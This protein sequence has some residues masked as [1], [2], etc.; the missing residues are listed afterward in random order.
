MDISYKEEKA[1]ISYYYDKNWDA[2]KSFLRKRFALPDFSLRKLYAASFSELIAKVH[3][4]QFDLGNAPFKI[5]LFRLGSQNAIAF[6]TG[7]SK[8]VP[9]KTPAYLKEY[10]WQEQ[11]IQIHRCVFHAIWGTDSVMHELEPAEMLN[12]IRQLLSIQKI[13]ADPRLEN[14][15]AEIFSSQDDMIAYFRDALSLPERRRIEKRVKEDPTFA[16]QYDATMLYL[17]TEANILD[18]LELI[19]VIKDTP[20]D[21]FPLLVKEKQANRRFIWQAAVVAL[22]LFLLNC[23]MK[24]I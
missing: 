5:Q 22:I 8:N 10:D 6:L 20:K 14:P 1:L 11:Y 24:V 23:L 18:E 13:K 9:E 15:T 17:E 2:F 21:I 4:H 19:R 16:Q 3:Q 12:C 7:L